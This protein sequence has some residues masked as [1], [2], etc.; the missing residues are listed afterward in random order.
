MQHGEVDDQPST[1][2][3]T[4][5]LTCTDCLVYC[6][7]D[8]AAGSLGFSLRGACL[9]NGNA[10]VHTTIG[11]D[12]RAAAAL[13][14]N[15]PLKEGGRTWYPKDARLVAMLLVSATV[16]PIGK[17]LFLVKESVTLACR[18]APLT[19]WYQL[20]LSDAQR[21]CLQCLRPSC[22]AWGIA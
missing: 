17:L 14:V 3:A 8:Q 11:S 10:V 16:E 9:K 6:A 1:Q 15:V 5:R 12:E 21:V 20:T 18:A 4:S 7:S 22:I 13:V 2:P 19:S